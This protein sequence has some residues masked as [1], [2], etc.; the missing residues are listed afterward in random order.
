VKSRPWD[1]CPRG[2]GAEPEPDAKPAGFSAPSRMGTW[3][4][5][6]RELRARF[7]GSAQVRYGFR[8]PSS[9][10]R[11]QS[12]VLIIHQGQKNLLLQVGLEYFQVL[13]L[14]MIISSALNG[15]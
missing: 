14:G 3:E 10:G 7:P 5:G 13:F 12:F 4:I 8:L 6:G 9:A 1:W 2:R 15:V 11:E